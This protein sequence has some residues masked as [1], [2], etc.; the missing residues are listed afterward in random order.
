MACH[1]R[2]RAPPR[3]LPHLAAFPP[4]LLLC[5]VVADPARVRPVQGTCWSFGRRRAAAVWAC[6]AVARA[7]GS[8]R[9]G[10]FGGMPP[11]HR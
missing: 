3:Q 5:F 9:K 6:L 10:R 7:T 4:F 8:V 2:P 11:L 1:P